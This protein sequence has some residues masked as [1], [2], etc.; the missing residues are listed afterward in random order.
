MNAKLIKSTDVFSSAQLKK[1]SLQGVNVPGDNQCFFR[2]VLYA[3]S[4]SRHKGSLKEAEVNNKAV[5]ALRERVATGLNTDKFRKDIYDTYYNDYKPDTDNSLTYKDMLIGFHLEAIKTGN[6]GS[7][8]WGGTVEALLLSDML[9]RPI[10]FLSD[11]HDP[12]SCGRHEL[13]YYTER[14]QQN[15]P[16]FIFYNDS[17]HYNVCSVIAGSEL[18]AW[19]IWE[20]IEEAKAEKRR[21]VEDTER[22]KKHKSLRPVP[23]MEA[24]S[25]VLP[26]DF[27]MFNAHYPT[28][29]GNNREYQ[30]L[31]GTPG[32][33]ALAL[34]KK[35]FLKSK[36]SVRRSAVKPK[37][38]Q[39]ADITTSNVDVVGPNR[40]PSP[41]LPL[42]EEN[43]G[44]H[45]R[46]VT[47]A[48]VENEN[49]SSDSEHSS[50]STVGTDTSSVAPTSEDST[51]V[52]RSLSLKNTL[53]QTLKLDQNDIQAYIK[54]RRAF[55]KKYSDEKTDGDDKVETHSVQ[56]LKVYKAPDLPSKHLTPHAFETFADS[57]VMINLFL[58]KKLQKKQLKNVAK[59]TQFEGYVLEEDEKDQ[60]E[61]AF[62][63]A[64]NEYQKKRK[65]NDDEDPTDSDNDDEDE[66]SENSNSSAP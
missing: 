46:S 54:G 43:L 49:P 37:V 52:I 24:I 55:D 14:T 8:S 25:T 30:P 31:S 47:V 21:H 41:S 27:L 50:A 63:Q 53:Q 2:S 9:K 58:N 36:Q 48:P 45:E 61:E 3:E 13:S 42:T 56:E 4:F 5:S 62:D 6:K 44:I 18:D 57:T 28:V 38:R 59:R 35:S 32:D 60:F 23:R 64:V 66:L 33:D 34:A 17:D 29:R 51:M 20:G 26:A 11:Q 16:I 15:E 40:P 39:K 12:R 1:L 10:I 22:A 19:G 65:P 7:Y